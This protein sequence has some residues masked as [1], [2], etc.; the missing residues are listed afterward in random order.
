MKIKKPERRPPT[1]F[2]DTHLQILALKLL[3]HFLN[4]VIYKCTY[5]SIKHH[6]KD[7]DSTCE[8]CTVK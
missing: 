4:Q 6:K 5:L 1:Q 3:D 7:Q 2:S 8:V